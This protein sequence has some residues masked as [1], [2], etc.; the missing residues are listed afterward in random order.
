VKKA[1]VEHLYAIVGQEVIPDP[2][3]PEVIFYVDG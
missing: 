3:E 2:G 1:L